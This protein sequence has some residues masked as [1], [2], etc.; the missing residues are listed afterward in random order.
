M[1]LSREK[2]IVN[3]SIEADGT[4]KIWLLINGLAVEITE[5]ELEAI[6]REAR[7][8][9]DMLRRCRGTVERS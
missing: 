7:P 5:E 3:F 8:T 2:G 4:L 6:A 1:S 9:V